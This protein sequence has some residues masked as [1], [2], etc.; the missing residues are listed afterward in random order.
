VPLASFVP[1]LLIASAFY[2][3]NKADQTA[4]R[5]SPGHP[6]WAVFG[7]IGGGPSR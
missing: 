3:L 2:Y 1:M 7:W 5:P 4:G 6:P